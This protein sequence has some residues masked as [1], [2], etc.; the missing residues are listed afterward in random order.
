[1]EFSS[2]NIAKEFTAAH[3]RS[4]VLG[5]FVANI[6]EAMGC[7]VVRMNY[8]GDWGKNL[9]LLGVGW[10]KYGS[11][12]AL[13]D[14]T[15]LFKY[16]HELYTKM[17]DE[18]RPELEARRKAREDRD[19]AAILENQGLFAARDAAFKRIENCEPEEI[20]LW[21]KLRDISIEYYIKMYAR[22]NITFDEYSGE[23]QVSLNS[24]A[25]TEVEAV[26]KN[27]GIYEEQ[28]GAW[29]IDYEKHG[30][31]LRT[32]TVRG[33]NGSTTYLLR[34]IA[35]VFDRHKT[36]SFDKMLYI[37]CEQDVHFRQV[38]KAVELMG[39]KDI[40]DKLQLITFA[41]PS[42]QS[43]PIGNAQLLGDILDHCESLMREAI[44]T[45]PDQYQV[46]DCDEAAKVMGINSLLIQELSFKKSQS[47]SLSLHL[48]TSLEDETGPGLQ[49]CYM[50][51][52]S[53][54]AS[55]G[56][57]PSPDEICLV[58]YS[59]LWD[60][61]W[62]EL[63]RLI[64]RYPEVTNTAFKALEPGLIISYLFQVA[65]ELTSCLDEAAVDESGGEGSEAVSKYAARAVL[66]ESV[67]QVLENGM[68]L[69]G[70]TPISK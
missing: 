23:S 49:L 31:P 16:I 55:I 25:V 46:K 34:D 30:V 13:S 58:D 6:Y 42:G 33:K 40:A 60:E 24:D 29:V 14:Q 36:H 4:T 39:R 59:S 18:L 65:D 67:R 11:E 38:F 56:S 22:L 35:T 32:A 15:N 57:Q 47:N 64:A 1:V 27:K 28:D 70:V 21:K 50:R 54:I 8:L 61:P 12:K 63:L 51:L 69:L 9:G 20:K 45:S 17:E 7:N 62:I 37:V 3:L 53:A 43:S 68:R 48:M 44:R 5:A 2:P 10:Q 41:K 52:C 19:D 26:L 66:Y